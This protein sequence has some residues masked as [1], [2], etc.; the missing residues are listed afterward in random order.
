MKKTL[1]MGGLMLLTVGLA[2]GQAAAQKSPGGAADSISGA[3]VLYRL[4]VPEKNAVGKMVIT[5]WG[6]DRFLIQGAGW[7]GEGKVEGEKGYY[8][9]KFEDGRT[10]R[11]TFVINPD[12]TLKGYVLG[13]GLD[14]RYLARPAGSIE[15][16]T[17][18]IEQNPSDPNA[19]T[20]RGQAYQK[21]KQYDDAI[22]DF[23]KAISLDPKNP[24]VYHDRGLSYYRKGEYDKAIED[25]T[26]AIMLS[27]NYANAYYLRGD[28]YY[29]KKKF[30]SAIDD[31]TKV[32]SLLPNSGLG[33]GVRGAVYKEMG[34]HEKAEKD[35]DA[36]CERGMTL[37]CR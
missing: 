34:L 3:Y 8:D 11:T 33:Y 12:G 15:E 9:W 28:A 4:E 36:A 1:L 30:E 21:M 37:W 16:L 22:A 7:V 14:W 19:Y 20:K 17:K 25:F 18:V 35:F 5:G 10:G 29:Q 13:S 27:P 31:F 6:G 24:R 23:D 2:L 26:Q 32:I